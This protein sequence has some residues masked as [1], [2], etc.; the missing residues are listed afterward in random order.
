[1]FGHA[2]DLELEFKNEG[3]STEG[4]FYFFNKTRGSLFV[5]FDVQMPSEDFVYEHAEA[6]QNL[7]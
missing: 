5:S 1:M 6:L 7:L 3:L 2:S 4:K